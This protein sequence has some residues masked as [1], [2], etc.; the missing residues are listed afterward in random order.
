M[1]TVWAEFFA[2]QPVRFFQ[3]TRRKIF[4]DKTLDEERKKVYNSIEKN[5]SKKRVE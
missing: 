2:L 3:K 1:L 4:F 5:N